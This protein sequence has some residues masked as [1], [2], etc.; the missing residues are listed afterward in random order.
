MVDPCTAT[1]EPA[2]ASK[3][4]MIVISP[5]VSPIIS[6]GNDYVKRKSVILNRQCKKRTVLTVGDRLKVMS[7]VSEGKSRREISNI[8]GVSKS[9]ICRIISTGEELKMKVEQKK[10]V[11][12][13]M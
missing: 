1:L 3:E 7:M 9:Q 6:P 11:Y 2:E 10:L 4:N 12:I 8:M 5:A 13:Q